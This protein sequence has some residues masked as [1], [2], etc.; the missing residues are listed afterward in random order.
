MTAIDSISISALNDLY[1]W[2]G[3][4]IGLFVARFFHTILNLIANR[5]E[6]PR[7]IKYR[8][9]N[10]REERK[11]NFEYLYFYKGDY[12]TLDQRDFLIKE[13]L[14]NIRKIT[15]FDY[16]YMFILL[17]TATFSIFLFILILKSKVI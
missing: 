8:N 17:L 6:R 7:R 4:V 15:P 14:K 13:R 10:G 2:S 9:L 3:L 1:F 16:R 11:D 5:F 12:Y